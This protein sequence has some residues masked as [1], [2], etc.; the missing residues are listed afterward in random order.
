MGLLVVNAISA[1]PNYY[2]ATISNTAFYTP[3][4]IYKVEMSVFDEQIPGRSTS[5]AHDE[6]QCKVKWVP[7]FKKVA[8][9]NR[10]IVLNLGSSQ[11]YKIRCTIIRR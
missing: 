9:S 11:E 2:K 8:D 4:Y 7:W 6:N 5:V 1:S 10:E 3:V